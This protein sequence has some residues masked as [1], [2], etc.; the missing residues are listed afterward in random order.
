MADE[1]KV[2]TFKEFQEIKNSPTI[3]AKKLA[4]Y[5]INNS[6]LII[7]HRFELSKK[8]IQKIAKVKSLSLGKLTSL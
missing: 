4:A 6:E 2:L 5:E 7:L 8:N 1:L 3:K